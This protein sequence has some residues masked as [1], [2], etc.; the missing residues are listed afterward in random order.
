MDNKVI[1]CIPTYKSY[2]LAYNGIIAA[3]N[4]SIAPDQ[5]IVIDNSGTAA[6]AQYLQPLLTLY[7]N[8]FVWPQTHNIG[9]A[10]SWNLFHE[11][12]GI[13]DII[14]ANDDVSVHHDTIKHLVTTARETPDQVLFAGSGTSGNAFSLFLLKQAGYKKIGPFDTHFYPA[15]FE[16]ND[17]DW[18]AR[19][20][21]YQ[22]TL[23]PEATYDHVGSSTLARY[24]QA[25]MDAHHNSFRRNHSYFMSK[26]GDEP[27]KTLY[28]EPFG[29]II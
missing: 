18:R 28:T 16:D 20:L 15:Y 27:G 24:T 5:I 7:K 9:V 3:L 26:W 1:Y 10:A 14:I 23:V 13:D 29:G 11:T 8:V 25:E 2:D 17:Y 21:G 22:L 4:G 19:L 12:L 6:A